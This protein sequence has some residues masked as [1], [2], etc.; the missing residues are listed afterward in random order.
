MENERPDELL[1]RVSNAEREAVIA[2]LGEA[3]GEGRITLDE[4]TDRADA[5]YA[6]RTRGELDKLTVDLPEPGQSVA[7]VV[8][9][10]N[11]ASKA[12]AR[13][14]GHRRVAV[15]SGFELSGRWRVEP[16]CKVVCVFGGAKLDL[17]HAELSSR[18]TVIKIV[19][20]FGGA[21]VV[22][23]HGVHVNVDGVNFMGGYSAE[24][25]DSTPPSGA[26]SIHIHTVNVLGG[27][28][29]EYD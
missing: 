9:A 27:V 11:S 12:V 22:V 23:P 2:R 6:A 29:V 20:V 10:T 17:R 26:P 16:E 19:A 5:V 3:C 14:R 8:P 24:P 28:S 21:Q 13:R 25:P 18:Q 7:P 1:L 4:F 15:L